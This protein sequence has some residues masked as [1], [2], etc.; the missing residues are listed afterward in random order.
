M[1]ANATRKAAG[2]LVPLLGL[3]FFVSILDRTNV[4]IAA[5]EMNADIGLSATA[6]GLGAGVFFLGYFLFE[7]PSNLALERFGARRWIFRIMVT[8]GLLAAAMALVQGPTSFYV[9]RFL[10]GAAEAGFFPGVVHYLHQWF[11]RREYAKVLA[12]LS[13]FGPAANA[14]GAPLS[15]TILTNLG[16]HWVYVLEALPAL[17]LAVV[18]LRALPDRVADARWLSEADKQAL[19]AHLAAEDT[20][21]AHVPLRQALR[22]RQTVL[23][24]VQY[25][26]IMTSSYGLVLWLPQVV[27]ALGVST[28]ATGWL[29]AI[30]FA[31]AAVGMVLWGRHSTR[32][33]E[34]RWHAVVPCV[35]GAAAFALGAVAGTPLLSMVLLSVAAFAVYTGASAFWALPRLFVT[36]TAAAAATALTNSFGNL[37]GFVG[38]YLTGYVRD[39]TGSFT[40]ALALL[41]VPLLAGGSMALVTGRGPGRGARAGIDRTAVPTG[42]TT[43]TGGLS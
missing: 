12:A 33:D 34:Q 15:T 10:L 16:W 18:V 36:G 2:R 9:L 24:C 19:T 14:L 7:V 28:T 43:T 17:V 26:L 6:Y 8:W 35:L 3:C 20:V 5:L 22:E 41:A 31:V 42:T 13:A 21:S 1:H 4:S 38:P 27:Q 29:S 30:P 32:T 37:G 39:A 25:L 11:G 23:M 40:L